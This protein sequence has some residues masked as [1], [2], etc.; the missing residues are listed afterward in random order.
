VLYFE[1]PPCYIV[2]LALGSDTSYISLSGHSARK[3]AVLVVVWCYKLTGERECDLWRYWEPESCITQW[4]DKPESMVG[5]T[6]S[7][8][9]GN[10]EAVSLL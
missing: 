9:W 2:L 4:Y 6:R 5:W 8:S 1:A 7:V 10:N 3:C